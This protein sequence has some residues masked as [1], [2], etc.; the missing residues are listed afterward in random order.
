MRG[1]TTLEVDVLV[2]ACERLPDE[3]FELELDSDD[4]C[5]WDDAHQSVISGL[6]A[7]GLVVDDPRSHERCEALSIT[8]LGRLALSIHY[9]I[10]SGIVQV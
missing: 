9:V 3:A 8:T 2:D 1:L 6:Q 10:A 5:D 4:E 7:R